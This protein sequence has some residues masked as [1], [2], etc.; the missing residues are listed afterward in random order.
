MLTA[1]SRSWRKSYTFLLLA[2]ACIVMAADFFFWHAAVGWTAA[3]ITGAMFALVAARDTRFLDTISGRVFTLALVGL[4]VALVE[5]PTWLNVTYALVC[6]GAIS[7]IN[8]QGG[9]RDFLPWVR[10]FGRWLGLGWAR[11]AVDNSTVARW[12]V[13]RGFSPRLARGTAAWILPLLLSSVFVALFAWANPIISGWFDRFGTWLGHVLENLPDL[14][15]VPRMMFWLAFATVAWMLLRGRVWRSHA[16]SVAQL[17][18]EAAAAATMAATDGAVP[19]IIEP[20]PRDAGVPLGLVLR[21]LVLFNLVFAVENV[22]DILFLY[23]HQGMD[24]LAYRQYVRRGAYPLVAAAL[25]AAL[26][27]L[28]KFR[29]DSDSEKS[30]SARRLVYAWVG[31]TILLTLSAAWRLYNYV[32]MS[33]L[34]RL[35]VA[36]I[37]WFLLVGLGLYYIVARI[38]RGRSNGWLINV[39]ALTAL[40]VLY[41][42]CFVNFDGIIANFNAIHCEE[43]GGGGSPLDIE[44]MR[45]LG[46][47]AV[48]PLDRVRDKI[49][50]DFRKK[51]AAEVSAELRAELREELAD[52]R[53]WTWRRQRAANDAQDIAVAGAK[54][55]PRPQVAQATPN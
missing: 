52:W 42:C 53:G 12:L 51:Q 4:L 26:F 17:N 47:T 54:Q 10:R 46:P 11:I 20:A 16:K 7:L 24:A 3:A 25:L 22:L 37:I 39:N 45:E 33:E 50:L 55:W 2:T 29:P 9:E 1:S 32:A 48:A 44:Y 35:R 19:P 8:A 41:P 34:T 21:C 40:L 28:I 36:S 49:T 15:N 14:I 23:A 30:K 43:V 13:R 5:Q 18:A 31:Q 27:V 38:V 6:L